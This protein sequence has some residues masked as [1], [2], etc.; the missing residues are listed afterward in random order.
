[1]TAVT[2]EIK[3]VIEET[4][5]TAMT[6]IST[7]TWIERQK[8]ISLETFKNTERLLY[9]YNALKDHVENE[10]EYM[11]MTNKGKSKSIV[12]Y[13][14][15]HGKERDELEITQERKESYLRSKS[16]IQRIERALN[17]IKNKKGYEVVKMKYLQKKED[18]TS[19]T[20]EEIA[21]E[22]AGKYEYGEKLA[23]RTVRTY[24]SN[25]VKEVAI[26]LF[27]T[28]AV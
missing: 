18:G 9:N 14:T 13:S 16:D 4:V 25:L 1:M 12:I 10:E 15:S 27:G 23:E 6:K 19:F 22:L 28:D 7:V 3:K 21:E 20:F 26:Q 5:D 8:A 24:R 11:G 17:K 2:K